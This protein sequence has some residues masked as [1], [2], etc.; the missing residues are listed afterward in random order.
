MAADKLLG[1]KPQ[2]LSLTLHNITCYNLALLITYS[3]FRAMDMAEK[4]MDIPRVLEPED[5]MD[6]HVSVKL[7]RQKVYFLARFLYVFDI[8]EKKSGLLI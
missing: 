6:P 1:F 8:S 3:S 2:L 7:S 5:M 4:W